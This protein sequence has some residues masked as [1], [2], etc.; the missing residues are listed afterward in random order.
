[1][2]NFSI[3]LSREQFNGHPTRGPHAAKSN[4]SMKNRSLRVFVCQAMNLIQGKPF[5]QRECPVEWRRADYPTVTPE[6]ALRMISKF[7]RKDFPEF[8]NTEDPE[9]SSSSASSV[10]SENVT[11]EI[12]VLFNHD[13]KDLQALL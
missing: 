12:P 3:E 9:I 8:F 4:Y 7:L 10:S 13:T 1:M 11:Y 2:Y 6:Q 5:V